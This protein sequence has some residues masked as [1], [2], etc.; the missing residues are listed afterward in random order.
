MG[1]PTAYSARDDF[2]INRPWVVYV[3]ALI[4]WSYGYA[5]DGPI[6]FPPDLA[7]VDKQTYDMRLFLERVGGVDTPE[8]LINT[9]DRNACMGM[10][11]ILK[12]MFENCRWEL[13]R[14]GAKLLNN[15][16]EMLE[17]SDT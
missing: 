13:L 12:A 3:A 8:D 10:L 15:C 5:L 2:L 6:K 9:P 1:G 14:E 16:I 7:T 4:V 11:Y 17:G